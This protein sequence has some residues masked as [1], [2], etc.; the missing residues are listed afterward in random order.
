MP[1][2]Q[3]WTPAEGVDQ[4]RRRGFTADDAE[5]LMR[6]Y[7]HAAT[8]VYGEPDGGWRVDRF[9]VDDI[10]AQYS[11]V[12]VAGGET[13]AQARERAVLE[14]AHARV[15]A[16]TIEPDLAARNPG[17][18]LDV[19]DRAELWADRATMP[20]PGDGPRPTR[21]RDLAEPPAPPMPDPTREKPALTV[22]PDP[23]PDIVDT[24]AARRSGLPR[25]L[26]DAVRGAAEATGWT[27]PFPVQ[28]LDDSGPADSVRDADRPSA[29]EAEVEPRRV[30]PEEITA[31]VAQ[32]R[33]VAGR[34]SDD[35][36]RS[37]A[38]AG[39]A[40][41][42]DRIGAD[43]DPP[44]A[45][46][47][48]DTV[49]LDPAALPPMPA[50]MLDGVE[51]RLARPV[52]TDDPAEI[53]ARVADLAA[54]VAAA[55]SADAETDD[56]PPGYTR[57]VDIGAAAVGLEDWLDD[58]AAQ[59]VTRVE[60]LSALR[61]RGVG[62][63]E[64]LAIVNEHVRAG[65]G[66]LSR[67][68]VDLMVSAHNPATRDTGPDTAAGESGAGREEV[69]ETL[70]ATDAPEHGVG[71]RTDERDA[72]AEEAGGRERVDTEAWLDEVDERVDEQVDEQVD[73]ERDGAV[74]DDGAGLP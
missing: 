60:A 70:D 12:D 3:P 33:A 43:A 41:L 32:L 54:R 48:T 51:E 71:W 34:G 38:L 58:Y 65:D 52:R 46:A 36:D 18:A 11:W 50:S 35:V 53:A 66:T 28:R 37:A 67:L 27:G 49:D 56:A 29:G 22:A 8:A 42:L 21:V 61:E 74:L 64:A 72:A 63:G 9:D 47:P 10:A 7:L 24:P 26:A 4:L 40:A 73:V 44:S 45:D 2:Y 6:Q 30:T 69:A 31:V 13:L 16:D 59:P 68:T 55:D 15:N 20:V 57:V 39:K 19:A 14:A 23:T 62:A 5:H 1:S 25:D 17:W